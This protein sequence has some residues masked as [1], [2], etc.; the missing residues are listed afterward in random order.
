VKLKPSS[1]C[2]KTL[3]ANLLDKLACPI[4]SSELLKPQN[5]GKHICCNSCEIHGKIINNTVNW[6]NTSNKPR[7][8]INNIFLW[9]KIKNQFN[10]LNSIFLP[11]R[12]IAKYRIEQ[13]YKRTLVDSELAQNWV[14]HN[15]GGL[16]IPNHPNVLDCGCGRGRNIALMG[17]LEWNICGQDIYSHPWWKNLDNS[18][19]QVLNIK[20]KKLPWRTNCFDIAISSTFIHYLVLEDLKNFF[21]EVSRIIKPNGY[22]ILLEANSN[23]Y[24]YS[25]LQ[26]PQ[27]YPLKLIKEIAD[28]SGFEV[29]DISYEGFSSPY[30]TKLIDYTRKF[31][32]PTQL[33]ISDYSSWL[34]H[35]IP[36]QRRKFWLL[37][38][39]KR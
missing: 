13:F 18:G 31:L 39:R 25:H 10:L 24:T 28:T 29:V 21:N 26:L 37:R 2:N 14:N 9:S 32:S 22:F 11:F 36:E 17:Q 3:P 23:A 34:A 15:L 19:F 6:L 7:K 20:N 16:N 27:I 5:N 33:D 30:F 1:K 12:Y 8:S 38:L 4:C 35:Q